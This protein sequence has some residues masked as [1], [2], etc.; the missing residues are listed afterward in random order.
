MQYRQWRR[1]N[2]QVFI[3][4]VI[5]N[6]LKLYSEHGILYLFIFFQCFTAKQQNNNKKEK[7]IICSKSGLHSWILE[8]A[9]NISLLLLPFPHP[10]K[11]I[12]LLFPTAAQKSS[13]EVVC[14]TSAKTYF[15][16]FG[17]CCS[18]STAY[19]GLQHLFHT[20]EL[21]NKFKCRNHCLIQQDFNGLICWL[22]RKTLICCVLK[23]ECLGKKKTTRISFGQ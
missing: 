9:G 10:Y 5:M 7:K 18:A 17:W 13:F 19:L 15:L 6:Y 20:S 11:V 2:F 22:A 3:P 21:S 23:L 4:A 12:W 8:L 14:P 1:A 16:P